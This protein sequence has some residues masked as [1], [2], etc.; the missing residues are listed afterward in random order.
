MCV[1]FAQMDLFSGEAMYEAHMTFKP[2]K[3][4]SE[5]FAFFG[6]ETSNFLLNS[7]SYFVI[8]GAL[9]LYYLTAYG[10][11][12]LSTLFPRSSLA[13]SIGMCLYEDS[14]RREVAKASCKLFLKSY[15]DVVMCV[16][17]MS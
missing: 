5:Q 11:N 6:I 9:L 12:K 1:V 4:P 15:F 17:Q 7:G 2:T 3:P 13:R 8:Q 10:V 16:M 14:Y